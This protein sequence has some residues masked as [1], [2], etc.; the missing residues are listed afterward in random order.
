[1]DIVTRT[2][3]TEEAKVPEILRKLARAIESGEVTLR[4]ESFLDVTTSAG[5]DVIILRIV[6]YKQP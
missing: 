6:G 3:F 5:M 2:P 1:M 4:P